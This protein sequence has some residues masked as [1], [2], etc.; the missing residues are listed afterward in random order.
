[1]RKISP[2]PGFDPRTV[3]PVGSRYTDYTTR[4]TYII[5]SVIFCVLHISKDLMAQS[6]LWGKL[7]NFTVRKATDTPN[8]LPVV[9]YVVEHIW[10]DTWYRYTDTLCE[11]N[12]RM[13]CMWDGSENQGKQHRILCSVLN[14]L[15]S[16]RSAVMQ[17]TFSNSSLSQA[18]EV[19]VGSSEKVFNIQC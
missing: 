8:K 18:A 12:T 17:R 9:T 14:L 16:L 5:L 19:S 2:P 11:V 15:P 10:S 7:L 4:P 13:A 1:V 3:Q 6:L